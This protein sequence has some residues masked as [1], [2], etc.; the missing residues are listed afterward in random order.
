M[1]AWDDEFRRRELSLFAVLRDP[2]RQLL[3]GHGSSSHREHRFNGVNLGCGIYKDRCGL[4]RDVGGMVFQQQ[5]NALVLWIGRVHFF[6]NE[7][8]SELCGC[9]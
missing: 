9:C 4:P 3:F 8:K 7:M 1:G 5:A 2:E 6:R